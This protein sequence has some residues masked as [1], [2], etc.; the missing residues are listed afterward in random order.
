MQSKAN[1]ENL[2]LAGELQ[3]QALHD[4]T[5]AKLQDVLEK[6]RD[7]GKRRKKRRTFYM[8]SGYHDTTECMLLH[9]HAIFYGTTDNRI[10]A[11]GGI[12]SGG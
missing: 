3:E 11:V 10:F 9:V 7:E 6:E 5:T 2:D 12:C 4:R 8:D 1:D